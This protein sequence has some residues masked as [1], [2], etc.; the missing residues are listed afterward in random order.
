MRDLRGRSW[1]ISR[2]YVEKRQLKL[3]LEPILSLERVLALLLERDGGFLPVQ[4]APE[5]IKNMEGKRNS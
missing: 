4:F 1:P 2:L 3:C 5:S